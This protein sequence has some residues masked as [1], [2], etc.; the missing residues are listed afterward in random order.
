MT[1]EIFQDDLTDI[2]IKYDINKEKKQVEIIDFKYDDKD[3]KIFLKLLKE[4]ID[5]LL[6]DGHK[7]FIQI[8]TFFDWNTYIKK[9][10]RWKFVSTHNIYNIKIECDL[11]CATEC[12]AQGF[13]I[14]EN[15]T[16]Y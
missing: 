2:F 10:K 12:V 7:K 14:F 5:K 4:S 15:H 6:N 3:I 8:T 16:E 11:D 9:D 13:G 1:T